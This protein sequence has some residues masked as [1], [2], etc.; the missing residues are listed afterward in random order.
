MC[1]S[2]ITAIL[3]GHQAQFTLGILFGYTWGFVTLFFS[4]LISF[5]IFDLYTLNK[6]MRR[7]SQQILTI[8]SGLLASSIMSA[9]IFFFFRKP[10]PRAVFLIFYLSVFVLIIFLRYLIARHMLSQIHWQVLLVGDGKRSSEVTQLIKSRPYLHTNISGY[11]SKGNGSQA[12]DHLPRLGDTQDMITIAKKNDID[13]VIVAVPT[14]DDELL[15]LLLECM[16]NKIKVSDFRKVI[17]EITGKVPIDHLNDNW[18]LLALS[19][20]DKRHFWYCKRLLDILLSCVGF[21]LALPLF[22]FFALLIKVDSRGPMF[23]SQMRMGRGSK[24]FRAWKLRTMTDGADRNNVH[25]TMDNDNRITRVGRFIR[26]T[27]LDEVP[28]LINILKG[29]MSLIGPRPEALSLVEMYTSAIPYYPERHLVAPGITGWA[30]INYP[31]GNSIEDTRQ[32]LMYDFY[33][34]K[35]RCFTLDLLIF[36]RTI[37]IVLTGKGAM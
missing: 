9:F 25:W 21:C 30:Q 8:G 5:L 23:Y 15:K 22:P 6:I 18:F 36:L 27:R 32:K 10:V 3:I 29:E 11:V 12:L 14:L 4:T 13:Q 19:T 17:E 33:Y 31:Y 20:L 1:I 7:F 16:Q 24:P 34:I 26:K 35:N 37:K 2:F 28:Q